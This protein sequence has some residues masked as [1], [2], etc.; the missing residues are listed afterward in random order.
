MAAASTRTSS[1]T[2][3]AGG[4]ERTLVVYHNRFASTSGWIRTAAVTGGP[5][6]RGWRL[7]DDAARYL[8]LRD[9]RGGLEYLR[10][11]SSVAR[12]GLYLELDA[13]KTY[14]FAEIRDLVDT[15]GRWRRL[16]DWLGGRGVPSL[17]V[18]CARWSSRH[19]T[20]HCELTMRLPPSARR[21]P[22]SACPR[23]RPL[24]TKATV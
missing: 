24:T 10:S 16:A 20:L 8:V 19:C 11:A 12:E 21:L 14:V 15:D 23:P 5:W 2:R 7:A 18:R 3:T 22:C 1:P 4:G 13:Y 9:W 17:E 6:A